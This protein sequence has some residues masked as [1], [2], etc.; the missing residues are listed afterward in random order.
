MGLDERSELVDGIDG[1]EG[2][3]GRRRRRGGRGRGRDG[4]EGADTSLDT[5]ADADRDYGPNDTAAVLDERPSTSFGEANPVATSIPTS[6]PTS[7]T[8]PVAAPVAALEPTAGAADPG[9]APAPVTLHPVN[10]AP[11]VAAAPAPSAQSFVLPIQALQSLAAEA[12]LQWV[13][14]DAQKVQAAQEAMALAPKPAHVPRLPK[15]RVVVDEGPLVL[16]ETRK[17]LSQVRMPF[18]QA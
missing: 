5:G 10:T 4:T 15:P 11:S 2:G 17:D 16:V 12:G 7:V 18:D 8:A 1:G 3:E 6:V 9:A 13:H 14:S